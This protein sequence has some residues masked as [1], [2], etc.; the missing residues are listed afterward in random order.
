MKRVTFNEFRVG[1]DI[2]GT[3][4][5]IIFIGENGATIIKKVLSTKVDIDETKRLISLI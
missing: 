2:G 3:F 5:D 4:T 1:I